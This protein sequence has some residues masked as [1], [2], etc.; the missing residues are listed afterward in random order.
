MCTYPSYMLR[1]VTVAS[2]KPIFSVIFSHLLLYLDCYQDGRSNML[3]YIL[4]I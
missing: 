1:V 3:L 4:H 2:E